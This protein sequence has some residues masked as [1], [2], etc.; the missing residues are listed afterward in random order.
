MGVGN[1]QLPLHP[2][3]AL[4]LRP[5]PGFFGGESCSFR[6]DKRYHLVNT[7][8]EFPSGSDSKMDVASPRPQLCGW[9]G[10]WN[11]SQPEALPSPF[12]SLQVGCGARPVTARP[13]D[14]GRN[15]DSLLTWWPPNGFIVKMQPPGR[16]QREKGNLGSG[17]RGMIMFFLKENRLSSRGP[18]PRPAREEPG[19]LTWRIKTIRSNYSEFC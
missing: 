1:C 11:R 10:I 12:S 4:G 18:A 15:L 8:Q 19:L 17:L 14:S 5:R 3:A 6:L 2:Q 13:L 16:G 7:W 9:T